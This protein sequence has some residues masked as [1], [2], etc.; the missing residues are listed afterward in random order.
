VPT[1]DH[2]LPLLYLA[3]LAGEAADRRTD[4]LI[5]GYAYGSLSMTAYTLDLPCPGAAAGGTDPA[6]DPPSAVPPDN[7]NI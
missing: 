4:V 3:G 5:D 2:F 7:S 1:P 6:T